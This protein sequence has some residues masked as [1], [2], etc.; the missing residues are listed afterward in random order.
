MNAGK[1]RFQATVYS[2]PAAD[3]LGNTKQKQSLYSSGASF[4]CN[5]V[6]TGSSE[7]EYGKGV[8]T[9]QTFVVLAR[10]ESVKS[11]SPKDRLLIN[12][13]YMNITSIS[14]P[15]QLGKDALIECVQVAV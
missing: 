11:V 4:R 6:S 15:D 10:W 5:L 1:L 12:S 8:T 9:L 13:L 3:V 14:N 7:V 2:P